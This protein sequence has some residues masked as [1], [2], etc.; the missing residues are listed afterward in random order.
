MLGFYSDDWSS[1]VEPSHGTTPFSLERLEQFIGIHTGY[2]SRPVLGLFAFLLSSAFGSSAMAF[3]WAAIA[4][5]LI[6]AL[7]LRSWLT[8]LLEVFSEYHS[9]AADLA[10]AFWLAM[11]WMLAVTCW[12][13]MSHT[14]L[15]Q[16][17]FT[18]AARMLVLRGPLTV[19]S[20]V[21]FAL[22]LMAS[23]L[24]YEA[25]YFQIFLV[26]GCWSLLPASGSHDKRKT[27][28]LVSI[29]C[30]AQVIPILLNR[31]VAQ[32][33]S[34]SKSFNARWPLTLLSNIRHFPGILKASLLDYGSPAIILASLLLVCS[35]CL[36]V[37]G[38]IRKAQRS[39]FKAVLVIVL[40]GVTS[41]CISTSIY[42]LAGYGF[43]YAGV[44]SRTLFS[45]SW[46]LSIV[47]FGSLACFFIRASTTLRS[48][49]ALSAI[50]AVVITALAQHATLQDW[51]Y[52]WRQE[53]TIVAAAPA[54]EISRLPPE[55]AIL[56]VGPSY[57]R[58]IVIFGASWDLTYAVFARRP[59]S[60]NRKPHKGIITIYPAT[61]LYQWRWDGSHLTQ[62]LPGYWTQKFPATHLY[63]WDYTKSRL[64]GTEPG[65][66][67]PP[68]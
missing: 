10:V 51:A 23:A 55:S 34:T 36:G 12:P 8:G 38:M 48:A 19:K 54:L 5:V 9:L 56:Y 24:S 45:A 64:G 68:S 44:E 22:L 50:A 17:F 30:V 20:A 21:R 62:E 60:E 25:F 31:Y 59:L 65:F 16:I 66:K 47:F 63:V 1:L 32:N 43:T 4:L 53:Q 39:F 41:F 13:V 29:A 42:S 3:Q 57:Y 33:G 49:L 40:L 46:S 26:I 6:A 2:G 14:L 15:A 7:S 61:E 35:L 58:N 11:P 52:I 37:I 27:F 67:W 18:E 28:M